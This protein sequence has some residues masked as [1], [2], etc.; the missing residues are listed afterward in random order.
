M[1]LF[2][3]DRTL[4]S[5]MGA[6]LQVATNSRMCPYYYR[7]HGVKRSGKRGPVRVTARGLLASLCGHL[8]VLLRLA[9]NEPPL[10]E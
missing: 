9:T 1:S 6:R 4:R 3:G 8:Q 10:L 2:V 7:A 5:T